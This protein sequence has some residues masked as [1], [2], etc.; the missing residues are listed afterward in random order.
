MHFCGV[1][2]MPNKR[3]AQVIVRDANGATVLETS[4]DK[5]INFGYH[6]GIDG[7]A[8]EGHIRIYG[9]QDDDAGAVI[10]G[11]STVQL[12]AGSDTR[13]GTVFVGDIVEPFLAHENESRCLQISAVDGDGF[14]SSYVNMALGAGESIGGMLEKCVSRCSSPLGIGFISPA[15]YKVSLARGIAILGS[16]VDAI[17]AAAKSLN[18]TF[19]VRNRLFYLLC[20]ND[21]ISVP[22]EMSEES[23]MIG[24]PIRDNYYV[25][26]RHDI[27]SGLVPGGF[28]TFDS[29][30]GLGKYRIASVDGIGDTLDGEWHMQIMAIAQS[31]D[32]PNITAVTNNIWR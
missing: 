13:Y 9:I 17:K 8:G 10:A 12:I 6:S 18:A 26:F 5:R 30:Y 14:F 22:S 32:S 4:G 1:T 19:F 7:R 31:G 28:I 3:Y 29:S 16:P 24:I 15:A 23:G 21:Y 27:D 25:S 2:Q 11:G 20:G